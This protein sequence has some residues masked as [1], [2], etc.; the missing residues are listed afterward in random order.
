HSG[1]SKQY[2]RSGVPLPLPLELFLTAMKR[3]AQF[4]LQ[5][6][7]NYASMTYLLSL[8]LEKSG[9][10][11]AAARLYDL[12]LSWAD[13]SSSRKIFVVRQLWEF[14]AEKNR[15]LLGLNRVLDP[16]F[17]VTVDPDRSKLP[18]FPRRMAAGY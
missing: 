7:I 6:G 4:M 16:L 15:S 2:P 5:A 9:Y 13:S 10:R 11:P 18:D 3:V 12:A 14:R 1:S 17:H 8:V